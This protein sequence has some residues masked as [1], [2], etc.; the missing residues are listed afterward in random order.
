MLFYAFF[1]CWLN[2]LAELTRFADRRFYSDWWNSLYLD[3]YW[4]KWNITTHYWLIRHI[5]NPLRRRKFSK[6]FCAGATFAFSGLFHEYVLSGALGLWSYWGF[7]AM[8]SNFPLSIIQIYI[9]E[10][11]KYAW[12]KDSQ[13]WNVLFWVLFCF[14]GQPIG[15]ILYFYNYYKLYP[16]IQITAKSPLN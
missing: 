10:S 6:I 12:C 2:F 3:E 13:L 11:K 5:Y 4:R 15:F 14:I 7:V 16:P 1:H 8:F 9:R